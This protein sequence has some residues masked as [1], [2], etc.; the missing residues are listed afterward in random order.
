[1][2]IQM[3]AFNHFPAARIRAMT[4]A[5][6]S[7]VPSASYDCQQAKKFFSSAH[8]PYMDLVLTWSPIS[9]SRVGTRDCCSRPRYNLRLRGERAACVWL[10]YSTQLCSTVLNCACVFG[11]LNSTPNWILST[12]VPSGQRP[13]SFFE[14]LPIKEKNLKKLPSNWV[15]T[16]NVG[17]YLQLK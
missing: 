6:F 3:L 12:S 7:E 9:S 4:H 17:C 16:W 5:L 1:M 13:D 8:P 10:V 11:V 2:T 14:S 15:K